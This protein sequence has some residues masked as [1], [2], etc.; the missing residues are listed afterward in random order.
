[1]RRAGVEAPWLAL[2]VLALAACGDGAGTRGPGPEEEAGPAAR[3]EL[4]TGRQFTPLAEGATLRLQRGCQ[5]SQHVFVSLRGRGLPSTPLMVELALTRTRDARVVSLPYRTRLPFTPG[6]SA[7]APAEL[8]GLLL[9][10]PEPDEA[11]GESVWLSATVQ[12]ESGDTLKDERSG[13]LQW[14]ADTCP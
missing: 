2:A 9:V 6:A 14:G 7:D 1:M 8:T 4:G 5:G 12:P 10:V 11:V 13:T 3:M